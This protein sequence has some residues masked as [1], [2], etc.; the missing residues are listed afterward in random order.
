MSRLNECFDLSLDLSGILIEIGLLASCTL[1]TGFAGR[2]KLPV[3]PALAMASC[4]VVL[5]IHVEYAVS[6]FNFS[7]VDDYRFFAIVIVIVDC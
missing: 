6:I 1:F 7:I 4:L 3:A 2:K 5:I